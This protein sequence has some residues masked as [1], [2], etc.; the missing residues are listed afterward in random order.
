MKATKIIGVNPKI[1]IRNALKDLLDAEAVRLN[2]PLTE[3]VHQIIEDYFY[4]D[5]DNEL[6]KNETTT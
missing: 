4:Y 3:L 2:L 5:E 6:E 1:R